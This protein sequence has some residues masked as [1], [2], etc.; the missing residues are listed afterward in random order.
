[1]MSILRTFRKPWGRKKG[2]GVFPP[3]FSF[4]IILFLYSPEERRKGEKSPSMKRAF[5]FFFLFGALQIFWRAGFVGSGSFLD[6]RLDAPS[7][8][9]Q[10]VG[11]R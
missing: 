11:E 3:F 7:F 6:R 4:I 5:F 8:S 2:G 9:I 1:M 10:R